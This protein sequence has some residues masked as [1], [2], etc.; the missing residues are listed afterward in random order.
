MP[1]FRQALYNSVISSRMKKLN[2]YIFVPLNV[3][4]IQW[5]FVWLSSLETF[6]P[7]CPKLLKLEGKKAIKSSEK[8]QQ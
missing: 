4:L 1:Q 6:P 7:L 8:Q 3:H 2:L 5:V